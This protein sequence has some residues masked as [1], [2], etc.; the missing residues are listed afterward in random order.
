MPLR[1]L[2][3]GHQALTWLEFA[4]INSSSDLICSGIDSGQTQATIVIGTLRV[5]AVVGKQIQSWTLMTLDGIRV[6]SGRKTQ[7][8]S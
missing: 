2:P 7:D 5:A 8:Y 1:R 3:V 6:E 4:K